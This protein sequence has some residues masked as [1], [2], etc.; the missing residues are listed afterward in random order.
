[1]LYGLF[2]GVSSLCP[3][4]YFSQRVFVG[5]FIGFAD[6][7]FHGALVFLAVSGCLFVVFYGS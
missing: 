3:K 7:F 6:C 2:I 1:M 5:P 4:V